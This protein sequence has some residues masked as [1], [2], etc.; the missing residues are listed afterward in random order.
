MIDLF[1]SKRGASVMGLALDGNRLEA[2][3]LRRSNG[4]LR[5]GP[6]VSAPL[7]LS[8]LTDPPELVGREIRNHLDQAGI[9]E[10]RCAVCV[11]LRWI[12]TLQAKLP[13]LSEADL[14]SFLQVEAERGFH[15]GPEDLFTAR[16]IFKTPSGD[17]YATLMAVP[18]NN[19]DS[20]DRVLRAAKLKPVS[21]S[22]GA[23]AVQPAGTSAERLITLVLRASSIDLQVSGG[24][25]IIALRSLD[26][27]IEMEGAQRRI[28]FDFVAR[29]IRITLGQLPGG[30]AEG[31]GRIKIFGQG[32][33]VRQFISD[34]SPRLPAIGLRLEAVERASE[35]QFDKPLPP[36]IAASPTVALAASWVG[37]GASMP[38]FLPPRVQAWH[39]WVGVGLSKRRLIW[40]AEAAAGLVLCV[41]IAFGLQEWEIDS[42]QSKWKTISPTVTE[43]N[44][45]QDQ[46]QK[47]RTWYDRTFHNLRIW[48]EL[49]YAFPDD[50]D[51]HVKTIEIRDLNNVTCSGLAQNNDAFVRVHDKL[52][53]DTNEVNNLHAEVRG[54]TPMQ[55]TLNFQWEGASIDGN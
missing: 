26:G 18:R 12:L 30:L 34:I 24:G 28:S 37:G 6:T 27:A 41:I 17:S 22:L 53:N 42:L 55:F 11:P 35:A 16:S 23:T 39:R 46:I 29:E 15:S 19:I 38:E 10:R 3:V 7:A 1:K 44:A 51:V 14:A 50:G 48:R 43:L 33:I 36:E 2:V 47:F 5:V 20:L 54:Q 49:T 40:A 52:G 13:D 4:T 9:R 45:D 31:M 32:E 8:P 21:F 25:G